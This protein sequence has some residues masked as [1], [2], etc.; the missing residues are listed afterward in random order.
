MNR[1]LEKKSYDKHSAENRLSYQGE[2]LRWATNELVA[3]HRAER[4]K[5][6]TIADIGCGIGLQSMAFAKTCKKVFA[7]DIDPEKIESAKVNAAKFK[8]KNIEFIAG[9]ALDDSIISKI[10]KAD[11]VFCDPERSETEES[12]NTGTMKPGIKEF[13]EKYSKVTSRIAIEFPPQIR[14]ISFDCEKEYASVNGKLNRLTLYFGELKKADRSAVVLPKGAIIV[15]KISKT[16][17]EDDLE[18]NSS[19]GLKKSELLQ[20][21]LYEA[22]PAV[23]KAGL[24]AEL[25]SETGAEFYDETKQAF[26]TSKGFVKSG[27]FKNSFKI[28]EECEFDDG[29]IISALKKHFI[30]KA[31]IRFNVD[32]KDYWKIRNNYEKN[33]RGEKK[34]FVFKL[35][36]KAV[37]AENA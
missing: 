34:A 11:V 27:F 14:E 20:A 12:R 5:C 4:L 31:E 17:K 7:V 16:G 23:Q 19:A 30:G 3:N 36:G 9:D 28:L 26:M 22:D 2:D 32:P 24:L 37:I 21:F 15:S 29:L 8:I 33:L 25:C 18:D 1:V 6:E 35:K 13:L 10:G